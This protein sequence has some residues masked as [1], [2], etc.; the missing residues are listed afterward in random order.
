MG[1]FPEVNLQTARLSNCK[2]VVYFDYQGD[3][4][5]VLRH[6]QIN[7]QQLPKIQGSAV[8]VGEKEAMN[9]ELKEIG[10]R[11]NLELMQV[12]DDIPMQKDKRA[13]TRIPTAKELIIL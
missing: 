1:L 3:H 13:K 8:R 9:V 5:L 12:L 7:T 4:K 11:L 2:R 10:P 6:Y